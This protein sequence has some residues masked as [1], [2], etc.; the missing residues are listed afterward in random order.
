MEY[1]RFKTHLTKSQLEKIGHALKNNTSCT[2][3]I[4]MDNNGAYHLMV[5]TRQYN[6]LM[7]GGYHDIELSKNHIQQFKKIHPDLKIGGFLPLVA[8]IPLIASA[9]AGVGG[10]TG[11]IATAVTKAKDSAEMARHNREVEKSLGSGFH[12]HPQGKGLHLHPP[13][14]AT[15]RGHTK[16]HCKM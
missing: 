8:L 7:K 5:S 12:L 13:P 10:I 14:P 4:K 16:C 1:N 6:K 3:R 11:G 15:G 2:I 9:L